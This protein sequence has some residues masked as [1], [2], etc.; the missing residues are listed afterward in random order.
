MDELFNWWDPEI[1]TPEVIALENAV[2]NAINF[3][4][5]RDFEKSL[6]FIAEAIDICEKNGIGIPNLFLMQAY[7]E[8][9]TGELRK[10]LASIDREI[11][12]YPDNYRAIELREHIKNRIEK[13]L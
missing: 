3:F 1:K 9:E 12:L 5:Q 4:G 10:A 8:M 13:N 7:A 6:P 2:A 11:Y